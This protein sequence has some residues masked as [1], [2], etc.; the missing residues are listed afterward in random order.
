RRAADPAKPKPKRRRSAVYDADGNEVFITLLC[1]KCHKMRPLSQFG[2]RK[3]AD[4]AIRNQPWCRTC[5][6]AAGAETPRRRGAAE[7]VESSDAAAPAIAG[8]APGA[9]RDGEG[10]PASPA[11]PPVRRPGAIATE[12]AAALAAGLRR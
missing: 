10:A 12:V 8:A 1:L 3:M 7:T 4:G 9:A 5:R 6:S 11:Q 2:L